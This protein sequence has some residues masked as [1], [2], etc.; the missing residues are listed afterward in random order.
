M[1]GRRFLTSL[2]LSKKK[3]SMAMQFSTGG[4]QHHDV[5]VDQ[6]NGCITFT[7]IKERS[8]HSA[9][10]VFSH[11]LGDM[12]NGW[13][14][15]VWAIASMQKLD[16]VKFILPTASSKPVS[17]N[18]GFVMPS[19]YDI[20]GHSDRSMEPYEGLNDSKDI[21]LD[22]V[23]SEVKNGIDGSRI[24]LAGFS[25]GAALS[26]Y[27]SFHLP[28]QSAGICCCSGYLP[29]P[30]TFSDWR[31]DHAFKSPIRIFHGEQDNVV[32]P[33]LAKESYDIIKAAGAEDIGMKTYAGLEHSASDEE[34]QDVA[35]ELLGMLPE[36]TPSL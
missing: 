23:E 19:W 33:S 32:P 36:S 4:V 20:E 8:E 25:Q 13:A 17:I 11:G 5:E 1:I 24:V 2:N 31:T 14:P 12:A 30:K 6:A 9:T 26:L 3:R 34:L 16:H 7:P 29:H 28:F 10:V 27:S 22:I 21:I 15:G 18:N 35:K